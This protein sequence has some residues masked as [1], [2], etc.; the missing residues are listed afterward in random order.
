M[1]LKPTASYEE[2]GEGVSG[3]DEWVFIGEWVPAVG[4]TEG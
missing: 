1:V 3:Y 2:I 4:C